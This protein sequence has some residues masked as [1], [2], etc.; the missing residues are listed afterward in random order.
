MVFLD[1]GQQSAGQSSRYIELNPTM[2]N[3]D[4]KAKKPIY[5]GIADICRNVARV[6]AGWIDKLKER[7]NKK[8][9]D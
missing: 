9:K 3:P 1:K 5:Q 2:A 6:V 7:M 8:K 4:A